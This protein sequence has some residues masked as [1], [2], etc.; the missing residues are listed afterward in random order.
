MAKPKVG[1]YWCASCGG[2]EEAVVD[3]A[4]NILTVVEAVDI[5]FWP[6]ALDFK[7]E[8]LEKLND[9]EIDVIFI[10]GAIRIGEQQEM[11]ELLRKK[12]K[13]VV[14]FGSCAHL[15]GIPGLGN[16]WDK[17]SIFDRVYHEVPSIE[18]KNETVP[19][20]EYANN[21]HKLSLPEFFQ[22]VHPLN[23]IIDVDYY[24]PGCP[25]TPEL[26]LNA[27]LAILKGELPPRGA[28][29][30]PNKSLCDECDRNKTKPQKLLL[31]DIKRVQEVD[32][33]P[34][35]CFL[36][37][38]LICM[39]PA[40]RSGCGFRCITGNMP[41]TG[42]FGPTDEVMDQGAKAISAIA[43]MIDFNDEKDIEKLTDKIVDPAGTFY[44]YSLPTSL[45]KRRSLS[46]L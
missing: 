1:F 37:Q 39:G 18:E 16:F 17:N 22:T 13:M 34:E 11:V 6:V 35:E 14:A 42:C 23:Q 19:L 36:A 43:S 41:C 38:G 21:G 28:V 31:K 4:E 26:V 25:P 20:E 5:V 33:D 44:R 9:A 46:N 29:L 24:L 40:T 12:S 10:N 7:R 27:V 8:D 15:G 3:L 2:C 45:L 30:S 32:L